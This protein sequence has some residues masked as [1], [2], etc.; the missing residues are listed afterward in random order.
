M[1]RRLTIKA[2][3]KFMRNRK[4]TM[5]SIPAKLPKMLAWEVSGE[6]FGQDEQLTKRGRMRGNSRMT[7]YHLRSWKTVSHW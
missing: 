2:L 5:L 6:C 7:R 3:K 4:K 1:V